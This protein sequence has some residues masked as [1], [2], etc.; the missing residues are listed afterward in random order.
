MYFQGMKKQHWE[1]MLCYNIWKIDTLWW[2]F[3]GGVAPGWW[4]MYDLSTRRELKQS[5]NELRKKMKLVLIPNEHPQE[6]NHH[7]HYFYHFTTTFPVH[8]QKINSTTVEVFISHKELNGNV[9]LTRR[10]AY[11]F[12][13][14]PNPRQ[15]FFRRVGRVA[16]YFNEY[17]H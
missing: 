7:W 6:K 5:T 14:Q 9:R 12:S 15:V 8:Q 10:A 13:G 4:W 2:S 16:R 1:C 17:V 3:T 11:T